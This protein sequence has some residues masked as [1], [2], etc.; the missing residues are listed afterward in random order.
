MTLSFF[1]HFNN[2]F[3]FFIQSILSPHWH[4]SVSLCKEILELLV[5]FVTLSDSSNFSDTLPQYCTNTFGVTFD[6]MIRLAHPLKAEP[7]DCPLLTHPL[8]CKKHR[9]I[10][11]Y[12]V[13]NTLYFQID[14]MY[15]RTSCK[16][17][18]T[19]IFSF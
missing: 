19:F 18:K 8:V 11:Q 5:Q 3:P 12:A 15:G 14:R 6:G 4:Q 16:T 7:V 13:E 10:V 9:G 2:N 1:L 17:F